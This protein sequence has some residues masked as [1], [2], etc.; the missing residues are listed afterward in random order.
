MYCGKRNIFS[1]WLL[2]CLLAILL[3]SESIAAKNKFFFDQYEILKEPIEQISV[4][5]AQQSKAFKKTKHL[6]FGY[7]TDAYWVKIPLINNANTRQQYVVSEFRCLDYVNFYLSRSGIISDSLITGYLRPLS[8]RQKMYS[9]SVFA[10]PQDISVAD[11]LYIRIQKKEGTL[12]TRFSLLNEIE[13]LETNH[14]EK[15]ILFFFFGVCFLMLIFSFSYYLY[16]RKTMFLWYILF[17]VSFAIH[18]LS[19]FGYGTMYIWKDWL[20]LSNFSRAF[21]NVPAVLGVVLFSYGLLRVKEFSPKI[22]NKLYKIIIIY[23]V[24]MLL[25]PFIPIPT[26]PFRFAVYTIFIFSVPMTLMTIV[27][28]AYNAIKKKHLP[29]YFFLAGEVVLIS[30]M[31]LFVMRNFQMLPAGFSEKYL[32]D[33]SILFM[34][35]TSM[36]FGL[37][38]MLTYTKE[39]HYRIIKEYVEQPK[40]EPKIYSEEEQEKLSEIFSKLDVYFKDQR[41]YLNAELHLSDISHQTDIPDHLISKAINL[42]AEMHFFDYVNSYRIQEATRLLADE[43]AMKIYTIEAL[44][45]QCGFSNKTSFN[46]AFKKFTGQTPTAYRQMQ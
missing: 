24:S 26:Y 35:I 25:F 23:Y 18:Q 1:G 41:P 29:G 10:L 3:P 31:L 14:I 28:A 40:A 11:T 9:R 2:F 15:Q 19:N 45:R 21:F 5:E 30:T 33:Y 17:V 43:E 6:N 4:A 13:L 12:H 39:M 36:S 46:K 38:S 16:F 34:G 22:I 42:K 8:T 27:I 44:A 20:W 7:S 32:S 37:I